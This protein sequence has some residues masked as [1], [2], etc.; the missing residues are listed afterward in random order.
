MLSD[1][2]LA[3][4]QAATPERRRLKWV[5]ARTG[6]SI[7]AEGIYLVAI[8]DGKEIDHHPFLAGLMDLLESP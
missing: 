1:E 2:E 3:E 4:W 8:Q 7:Q 5:R 6:R